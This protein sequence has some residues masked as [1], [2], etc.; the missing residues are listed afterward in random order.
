MALRDARDH[1]HHA[2]MARSV[3]LP[4]WHAAA[5]LAPVRH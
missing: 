1:G 3:L 2:A 5:R 4:P